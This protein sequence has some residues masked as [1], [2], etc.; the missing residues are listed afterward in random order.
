MVGIFK[1]LPRIH[2]TSG[3]PIRIEFQKECLMLF[4][5]Y[6]YPLHTVISA[7]LEEVVVQYF[8]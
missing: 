5:I 6:S 3:P 7:Y 8:W 1:N 4:A 2:L